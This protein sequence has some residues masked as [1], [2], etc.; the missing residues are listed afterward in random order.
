MDKGIEMEL[1]SGVL[2]LVRM[3]QDVAPEVWAIYMQQ[4]SND[5]WVNGAVSVVLML[6]FIAS[7]VV[8]VFFYRNGNE[9]SSFGDV[10]KVLSSIVALFA[11]ALAAN[12]ALLAVR[13]AMNPEYYAI[14]LLLK[15]F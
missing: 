4:V 7:L 1:G 8:F 11:L 15:S 2:E 5:V 14:Q 10:A 12:A 13:M 9:Y 6:I 3:L